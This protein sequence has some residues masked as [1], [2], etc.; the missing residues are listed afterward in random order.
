MKILG[1]VKSAA[2]KVVADNALVRKVTTVVGD[3]VSEIEGASAEFLGSPDM[4]R[5]RFSDR[6]Y[7]RLPVV[8]QALL[9]PD[10]WHHFSWSIKGSIFEVQGAHVSL[11]PEFKESL[12]DV[13]GQ[14]IYGRKYLDRKQR[15]VEVDNV[16]E[17]EA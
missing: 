2:M 4:F 1:S 17:D 8:V 9:T 3:V 6:S 16:I 10:Q 7:N 13:V 5:A 14:L 12:H 15:I 11:Q